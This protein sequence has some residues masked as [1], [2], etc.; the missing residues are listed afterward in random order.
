MARVKTNER[1][2]AILDAAIAV[3]KE[4]S[5]DKASMDIIATR[6][7]SSK[8]TIYRYF[9]NK[10][11]L[12]NEL[13]Q[14]MAH[15]SGSGMMEMVKKSGGIGTDENITEQPID[16]GGILNP[17]SEIKATLIKF[18]EHVLTNFY[19]SQALAVQRM[20]IGA[21]V[22][23]E[24]GRTYYENATVKSMKYVQDFFKVHIEKG[25][26]LP[27]DPMVMA[28]HLMAL[29]TAEVRQEGLYNLISEIPLT[30]A[31]AIATRAI[32]AFLRAYQKV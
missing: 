19:T 8:A 22:N 14:R 9:E 3:F 5:F 13:I 20:I 21:C 7:G 15:N 27:F 30:E 2:E 6:L 23:P 31:N 16:L 28:R 17:D 4:M 32:E 25:R 12:F 10:E 24:V 18:A 29:I 11:E 1:R 26:M